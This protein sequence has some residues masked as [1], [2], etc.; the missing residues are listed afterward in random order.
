M[1]FILEDTLNLNKLSTRKTLKYLT[2]IITTPGDVLQKMSMIRNIRANN[3]G[4]DD[5]QEVAN[6]MMQWL[7][8]LRYDEHKKETTKADIEKRWRGKILCDF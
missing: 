6:E 3:P 5:V 7:S 1:K 2:Q 8:D 4:N